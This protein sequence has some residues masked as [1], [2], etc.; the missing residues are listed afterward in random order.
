M[1]DA[2]SWGRI[3]RL[4]RRTGLAMRG[5]VRALRVI[6]RRFV[7]LRRLPIFL[8]VMSMFAR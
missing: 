8:M 4:R 3:G 5:R 7:L 6:M 1:F 2:F